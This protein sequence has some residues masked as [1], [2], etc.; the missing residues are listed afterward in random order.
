MQLNVSRGVTGGA[1]NFPLE[2]ADGQKDAFISIFS[3]GGAYK[4]FYSRKC[5]FY[6]HAPVLK[7]ALASTTS[8]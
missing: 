3:W 6:E 7:T 4:S 1:K 5:F 2:V 8:L